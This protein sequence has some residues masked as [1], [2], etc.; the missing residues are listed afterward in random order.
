[1]SA[2]KELELRIA[3]LEWQEFERLIFDL[4]VADE[5]RAVKPK[6]PDSGAD[7]L[8]PATAD[9]RAVVYQVKHYPNRINWDQCEGSMK[10]ALSFKP[11]RVVFVFP[12]DLQATEHKTFERR[13]VKP[14]PGVEVRSW[15][16]STI[17]DRLQR[18]TEVRIRYFGQDQA[19]LLES[20]VQTTKD[21]SAIDRAFRLEEDF[22]AEDADFDYTVELGRKLP[23]AEPAVD[24][25]AFV[26]VEYQRG[27]Q[28]LRL[29][30]EPRDKN[31]PPS[32]LWQFHD[33]EEGQ[34]ARLKAMREV[35]RGDE[36][37][38]ITT[39]FTVLVDKAPKA[40]KDAMSDP[41]FASSQRRLVLTPG[42]S[43]PL[44]LVIHEE[45]GGSV[46]REFR[47]RPFP[48]E[49]GYDRE[50]VGVNEAVMPH[51]ALRFVGG[52][53]VEMR[54]KPMLDLGSSATVNAAAAAFNLA[55]YR[56]KGVDFIGPLFP[57][58]KVNMPATALVGS[59]DRAEELVEFTK[60]WNGVFEAVAYIER[61]VSV[62]VPVPEPP[63]EPEVLLRLGTAVEILQ[64][65]A[66][67]ATFTEVNLETSPVEVA[68]LITRFQSH[69]P[70]TFPIRVGILGTIV[71]LGT[72]TAELPDVS[73][74]ELPSLLQ[75][76][77]QRTRV[78]V[79]ARGDGT[80]HFRLLDPGEDP[81]SDAIAMPSP[82]PF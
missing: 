61:E 58:G 55:L 79:L 67:E 25:G 45:G 77:V 32:A 23:K 35:G 59:G 56:A 68:G 15:T 76:P 33:D 11:E 49:P 57:D 18:D 78:K 63:Y 31:Q 69:P 12:K 51:I 3:G 20:F 5:P 54:F 82:S 10:A 75:L 44:E 16:L 81:P 14:N 36:E 30:A 41:A 40:L 74:V 52:P 64:N 24:S 42:P 37:V 2:G 60:F 26:T 39:G 53:R 66:G 29:T 38:E 50:Y 47:V 8:V 46:R 48:P 4:V 62:D 17:R 27:E 71:E 34:E 80:L 9:G 13:L 28:R 7:V 21:E 70:V 73:V 19:A 72:A 6:P 43:I 65:R 1:M 22:G